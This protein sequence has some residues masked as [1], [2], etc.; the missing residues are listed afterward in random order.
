M[1]KGTPLTM[2]EAIENGFTMAMTKPVSEAPAII[3]LHIRDYVANKAYS[4]DIELDRAFR[5]F[6]IKLFGGKL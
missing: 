6:F 2:R 3:E 5:I 1:T 4:K